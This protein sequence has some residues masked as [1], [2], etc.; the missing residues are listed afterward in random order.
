MSLDIFDSVIHRQT[1]RPH[2]YNRGVQIREGDSQCD[3][4][5]RQ[6]QHPGLGHQDPLDLASDLKR[7]RDSDDKRDG[8]HHETRQVRSGREE[9]VVLR[10]LVSG[11]GHEDYP[12]GGLPFAYRLQ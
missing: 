4:D 1:G 9:T 10:E 5:R 6:D 8:D 2:E 7:L 3:H 12:G 11:E